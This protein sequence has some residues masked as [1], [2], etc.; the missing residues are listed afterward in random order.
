M[1]V[2]LGDTAVDSN[3]L[4][5]LNAIDSSRT[6][7]VKPCFSSENP[8]LHSVCQQTIFQREMF[9]CKFYV[10]KDINLKKRCIIPYLGIPNPNL[11]H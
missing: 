3:K 9:E 4:R 10:N 2:L 6:K 1:M 8:L 7:S 5:G 11:S